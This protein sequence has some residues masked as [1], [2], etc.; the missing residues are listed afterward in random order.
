MKW[1]EWGLLDYPK[2]VKT[3]MDL[4]LVKKKLEGGSYAHPR[5]FKHDVCLVFS[6]CMAYNADG[7]EYFNIAS[8]L[9]KV[10]EEKYAKQVKDEGAFPEREREGRE[11]GGER[12]REGEREP[13]RCATTAAAAAEGELR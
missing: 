7:S 10:F 8:Q 12:G 6:N 1:K 11:S 13:R 5:E 4:G 3:P 9:K 2:V